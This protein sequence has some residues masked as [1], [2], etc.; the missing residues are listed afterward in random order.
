MAGKPKPMSQI[1]QLLRLRKQGAGKKHIARVLQISRNTVKAYLEKI[2]DSG[3]TLDQ[4]LGL[5]DQELEQYFHPG[6]PAY[7]DDRFSDFST[8]LDYLV[9]ELARTGVTRLGL[10]EEYRQ[11]R[12]DGYGYS[13][14]CELLGRHRQSCKP[15]MVLIHHAGEKLFFDFA[16]KPLEIVDRHT[17]EITPVQMFVACLPYSDYGFAMALPTQQIEDVVHGLVCCLA[18]LGGAPKALVPD[19]MKTAIVKANRY[20]PDVN[21]VLEDLANHYGMTVSPT[22]PGRPK[23]KALVENQVKL[24]Y[25]R[26]YAKLRNQVF[27]DLESLNKAIAEKVC[28]HNQTRMQQKPYSRQECFLSEEKPLLKPLPIQRFEIKYT[29]TYKVAQNNHI[30]LGQDKHYYSVPHRHIGQRVQVVYTRSLVRIFG[31]GQLLAAHPRDTRPGRY[32]TTAEHLCSEHQHYLKRSPDYYLQRALKT[33]AVLHQLF[34]HIFDQDRY[35]ETLYK[36]CDGILALSRKAD[37]SSFTQACKLAIEYENYSYK[38]IDNLLKNN[39]ADHQEPPNSKKLPRHG[40]VRGAEYF[41][42]TPNF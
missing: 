26:V 2:T 18:A 39:M 11:A 20:E 31:E 19:N 33:S 12:P 1:K 40:N 36:T 14:F 34:E 10:W 3:W 38:F 23:D 21:R 35:P 7:K 27:Y 8:R 22:R 5:E 6:S 41:Q 9:K 32:S 42:K 28:R 29:R 16:G 37:P 4:L 30:Y 17:G 24:I 15:S 13:Q 25:Q